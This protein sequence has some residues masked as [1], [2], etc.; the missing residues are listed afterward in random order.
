M[1][2]ARPIEV[3]IAALLLLGLVA[4][5]AL[6]GVWYVGGMCADEVLSSLGVA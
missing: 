6:A 4:I 2:D 1:F 3:A 5:V